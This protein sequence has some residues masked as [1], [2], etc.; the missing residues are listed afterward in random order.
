[1]LPGG[2]SV[3]GIFIIDD[4]DAKDT[5]TTLRQV[6]VNKHAERVHDLHTFKAAL[7]DVWPL[8]GRKTLKSAD[9]YTATFLSER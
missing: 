4:T 5:L 2:L 9:S 8:G 7:I 3:L 6:R 1:M